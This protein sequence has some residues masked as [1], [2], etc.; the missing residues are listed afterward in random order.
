MGIKGL[1]KL[2]RELAPK[3]IKER[4]ADNFFA[5]RVAIDASMCLYQF[6]VSLDLLTH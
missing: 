3:T 1:M 4:T 5:R 2:L 6:L